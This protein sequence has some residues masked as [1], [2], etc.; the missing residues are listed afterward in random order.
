MRKIIAIFLLSV[1]S[2]GCASID[3]R[4]SKTYVQ[5]NGS[6]L[7]ISFMEDAGVSVPSEQKQLLVNQIREG[8]SQN[9]L[10]ATD[11][12]NSQ[13]SVIVNI[14]T[15]RMRDDA[16]R[17]A[18]GIMAGCDNI[19]ST[20][21]VTDKITGKEIGNAKVSIKECAAWGVAS[22][23]ITKYTDGVVAYLTNK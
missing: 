9:G 13:H 18:V 16:A 23:V 10:L 3:S 2:F 5:G 17:L 8:L 12:N 1:S 14:H 6:Q 19:R 11:E 21:I 22:Q 15:F 4:V 20:V 7:S